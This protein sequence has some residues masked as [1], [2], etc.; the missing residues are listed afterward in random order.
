MHKNLKKNPTW[1]RAEQ[2]FRKGEI[3]A[4]FHAQFCAFKN[5]LN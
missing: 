2:S 1:T 5:Y 3:Q 4:F